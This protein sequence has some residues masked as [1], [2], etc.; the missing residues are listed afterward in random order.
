[1][2]I[3]VENETQTV[4]KKLIASRSEYW[5]HFD[6]IK[7]EKGQVKAGRCKYCHR[8]I[9]A[10]TREHGTSALKKHFN[11]CKRN[12]HVH[13]KDPKQS[14][15]QAAHGE[16]PTTWRFDQAAL[17]E[18]FAQMVIEDEQP[19]CFGEKPG[20]T[21]FLAK[22]CPRF[23]PPSRRTCTRDIVR[24][25]FEEKAK[26]KKFFKN[27]CQRVCLTTDCWTSQVQDPYMTVTA[28][29]IDE[30][31]KLHKKVISFF[32]IKGHK[33][34]DI[35]KNL[36]RCLDDW[37]LHRVM[38]IT[39]DNA[40]ANDSGVDYLRKQ[41]QKTNIA[42]G[43]FMHMRCG[44]HVVNMIVKDGLQEADPSIKRV[45]AAVRYIKN[46]TSRLVKFKEIAEE[47][48]VVSKGFLK[49]DV[50]TRWNSTHDMLKAAI[51][52]EKVFL[53]LV[54]DDSNYVIDLSEAKDGIGHPDEDDWETAK[55]MAQFLKRFHDLTD[56]IS[57]TLQ[58]TSNTFFHE[59]GEV[60]LL[61]QAW[62]NSEDD[63]QV[64]MGKRM[65]EKFDKYWGL[66]H[67][68]SKDNEKGQQ[69]DQDR[70]KGRSKGRG[71]EKEKEKENINL[72]IFV[73]AFLD[74][75]YK[76][77]MYTKLTVEEI[78]GNERGQLVWAAINTCVRELFEEYKN[79]Y[80]PSEQTA[81]SVDDEQP[82]EGTGGMLREK[83]AK[84]MK[85]SNCSTSSNKSEL[86]KYL[87]EEIEDPEK[88][89]D[90]LAWWKVNSNRFPVLGHMA[91]DVLAIPI[92]S[93]ASESAFSTVGR[94]M[95]DFRTSLTPFMLEALVCTQDWLRRPTVDITEITEELE[96]VEKG[97][98]FPYLLTFVNLLLSKLKKSYDY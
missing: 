34:E 19:F 87:V 48:K 49:L 12:P 42:K 97:I 89:I 56:R 60:S 65:K 69:Q 6:K 10:G 51:V 93:V 75:R 25:Y 29:F 40:S 54:D 11:I 63:L 92:T 46:G 2:V 45:R 15:L 77:S 95:D 62:L 17:R 81:Q 22:A 33:G 85:L 20:L 39:V 53:R 5:Q 1:V 35:G 64:T 31:W 55:K 50:P 4:E 26:L 94:I 52:Y 91:R 79:M 61:I 66:W 3:D 8:E 37:G 74:P 44:A 58:V 76:L 83:I 57:S 80:S 7:D 47:E 27:S 18:A 96:N 38:T 73:A 71:K 59:I 32:K 14:I 28:S 23:E 67:T 41:L 70:D 90:I 78:F 43:K 30:N 86:E 13:N 36:I 9:K 72:L 68:N 24:L 98:I 21:K 16:A 88:E 82:K 84:R